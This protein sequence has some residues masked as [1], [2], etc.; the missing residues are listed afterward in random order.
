LATSVEKRAGLLHSLMSVLGKYRGLAALVAVFIFGVIFSPK[1]VT[2]GLPIFLLPGTQVDILF[3]Y[4]DYGLLAVGMTLVILAGGIDLSVGSVL[5]FA[6]TLFSLLMIAYGWSPLPAI[7]V[8]VLAGMA[9]GFL[10]GAIISRYKLQPFVATLAMMVAA[11][12]A[13][14]WISGGIK[15][16]PGATPP[17]PCKA[18]PPIFSTG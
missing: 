14:K 15:V 10:S 16:Q 6:A 12:G 17:M 7:I 1:S 9:M 4:A 13:A 11:R 8:T 5:G 18:V 3:A 2:N